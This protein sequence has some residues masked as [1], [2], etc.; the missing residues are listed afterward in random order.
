MRVATLLFV[1]IVI[2]THAVF[3]GADIIALLDQDGIPAELRAIGARPA[4]QISLIAKSKDDQQRLTSLDI[5][6]QRLRR[7]V[8]IPASPTSPSISE[9]TSIRGVVFA[10]HMQQFS[11]HGGE[12]LGEPLSNDS[13]SADQFALELIGAR[14]AWQQASGEGSIIGVI[15]TGIDWE[16]ED[17]Q[18]ALAISKL[19]DV[20]QNGRFDA[21]S[22]SEERSGV[23]GD[24]NGR[25]DDNNGM[26]D[27]VIGA[28][29]VDQEY[30]NLGDDR[31]Y[32]P[33]PFDEHG[34]GTLVAGVIA[35][36]K[37]NQKGIAGLA[38]GARVRA[39][40]AFDATGSAE[41]DDIA[42]AIV[43]AAVSGVHIINMSFG[44]GV[45]SPLVQDAIQFARV[46]GCVLVA[47]AGNSGLE[48]TQYPA[49]YN[50]VIVVAATNNADLRAP[51]SSTGPA[52]SLS[53]PGQGIITTSVN[54]R[55]RRVSGTS[56]SAPYVAAAAALLREKFPNIT[57]DEIQGTLMVSS[58]DL[59]EIGW[60]RLYGS[61]RL[62]VDAALSS[63][64]RSAV[65]IT[66]PLN[67][68]EVDPDDMT[69][70]SVVGSN[71]ILSFVRSELAI[72][73]GIS[74]AQWTMVKSS[75]QSVINDT[76]GRVDTRNLAYGIHTIRVRS[77]GTDGRHHDAHT[78]IRIVEADSCKIV[79]V[80]HVAA[81]LR[82]R[83][84]DVVTVA[85]SRPTLCAISND[86]SLI[87]DIV[88]QPKKYAGM[89]SIVLPDTSIPTSAKR[90]IRIRCKPWLG[91]VAELTRDLIGSGDQCMPS[92]GWDTTDVAPWA[93]YVVNDVRDLYRD[94]Y[95][96]IVM[97]DLRAGSFGRTIVV[98]HRDGEWVVKD[99]LND[100][101]IPRALCDVNGNG[102]YEVVC[103][104]IGKT[105]LFEQTSP[106]SSLFAR[107]LFADTTNFVNGAGAADIDGDGREEVLGLSDEG[108]YV[109]TCKQG[110]FSLLGIAK[111]VSPPAPDNRT[112]RVDEIS[113]ATGD[114]NGNSKMEIAFSDT[115]GD[116]I[117]YE[118]DG[119]SFKQQFVFESNGA[120]GSGFVAAGD[121]DADGKPEVL[122]G[123][124]D[125][126]D[127]NADGEYGRQVWT[128]TLFGHRLDSGYRSIW[129]DYVA[130]VR[131]G[132]GYRNGV[133]ITN[134]DS[135]P[136]DE[137]L[138][139]AFPR[140]YA[141]GATSDGI[142][143]KAF[144]ERVATPR[145]VTF[146]VDRDGHTDL[147][148]G[149]SVEEVGAMTN[150]TFVR[151]RSDS[152]HP[153]PGSLRAMH[154]Q[155]DTA[156]GLIDLT[157]YPVPETKMYRLYRGVNGK[158][159]LIAEVAGNAALHYSYSLRGEVDSITTFV[160][161]ALPADGLR[162]AS[163]LSNRATVDVRPVISGVDLQT[164]TT[165]TR[166]QLAD[167]L[168][169]TYRV[170]GDVAPQRFSPAHQQLVDP[171]TGKVLSM[172]VYGRFPG[173]R[174][175]HVVFDTVAYTGDTVVISASIPI[176]P[177]LEVQRTFQLR[178]IDDPLSSSVKK[179]ITLSGVNVE[180]SRSI[181]IRF[182]H[183]VDESALQTG[184]YQL[185]PSGSV[186]TADRVDES[187]IRLLL[188][189]NSELLP[190]GVT[191]AITARDI[192]Y[193][194]T[195]VLAEGAGAT[196]TFSVLGDGDASLYAYPQPLHLGEHEKLVFAG[197][198]QIAS[199][200]VFDTALQS[201]VYLQSVDGN[202]GVSWDLRDR[203]N[204]KV[205]P[206]LY[207]YV[208]TSADQSG[209]PTTS[210]LRKILIQR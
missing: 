7:Y 21:W 81:W 43:Y 110:V 48:S 35:A 105:I 83:K 145:I 82:D 122:F 199:I 166:K 137:L 34:H 56:F 92:T 78:R 203:S 65:E 188:T 154:R 143:P 23:T 51:F 101:Y 49:S 170:S 94:G 90:S 68:V 189:P 75:N 183:R 187:R 135:L 208:V 172:A 44:D 114:F 129:R 85:T 144:F 133:A 152:R 125:S 204:M 156:I 77:Y 197:L 167:G 165:V 16:H 46:N 149:T 191:Y 198:P 76:I 179:V 67:E 127:A 24:L 104:V 181:V 95:P 175:L 109:Y 80:D 130:G 89:H 128:Y 98:Q 142:K 29:F 58:L 1:A 54:S 207:Y 158:D 184:S 14:T 52:L 74:P 37:D 108:C 91:T 15:D 116:L 38:H 84:T 55:Y 163:G 206:G 25:D 209:N 20:N 155:T 6:R 205:R 61:G 79:S 186:S 196:L 148:F 150:F 27:D 161:Q 63:Y 100:T 5:L 93:G 173:D 60:D 11:L 147:G 28:D 97:N 73:Q 53:A 106:S 157:W 4:L 9:I 193:D 195:H 36:T 126:L 141:F 171:I 45:N 107:V 178:V 71:H 86:G 123:V 180:S 162:S 185:Y 26:I 87:N 136:G 17:L 117:V 18:T 57:A 19:E 13:L 120:G 160:I 132:I 72:G 99:S 30:R 194:T 32:D 103:H 118:W 153:T 121:V 200:E 112:N 96:C 159:T 168:A 50:G 202:G 41:E 190:R 174:Q 2:Q 39:I 151:L 146:D 22:Q 111:N 64:G 201:V 8:R 3:A 138:I 176:G 62:R 70:L 182:S 12:V 47:S 139:S 119:S 10:W 102:L 88:S 192:T 131:Y 169:V 66:S 31:L 33:V 115:D 42:S 124:P 113:I 69:A 134:V 177:N 210:D 40:R 164:T 140:L 59:G